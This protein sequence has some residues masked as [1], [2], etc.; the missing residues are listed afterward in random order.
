MT[1][2]PQAALGTN[3][4]RPWL[5]AWD[6]L[7][8]PTRF[9]G[10]H[11]FRLAAESGRT[12]GLAPLLD[13]A[14]AVVVDAGDDDRPMIRVVRGIGDASEI[15]VHGMSG[16]GIVL[17]ERSID[18]QPGLLLSRAGET[19]AAVRIDFTGRL[20]SVVWVRLH[21]VRLRHGTRV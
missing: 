19:T 17:D 21:P 12:A 14:V 4:V 15:L 13:P 18:G 2:V 3:G 16:A 6:W 1:A 7:A 11:R 5:A 10:V 20:I 8:G 9:R